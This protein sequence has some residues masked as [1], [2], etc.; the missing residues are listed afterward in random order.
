MLGR[1]S[2][3]WPDETHISREDVE[4]LRQLIEVGTPK[5]S[6]YSR[7]TQIPRISGSPVNC[8]DRHAPE[9]LEPEER[10]TASYSFLKKERGGSVFKPYRDSNECQ[11][12][13]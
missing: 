10:P 6:T 13:R 1:Q 12:R 2:G 7:D 8:S 5:D 9:L 4:K 3:A 11:K